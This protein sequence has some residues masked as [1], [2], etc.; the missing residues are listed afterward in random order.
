MAAKLTKL[1]TWAGGNRASRC[2]RLTG[3]AGS[4]QSSSNPRFWKVVDGRLYL[5][6]NGDIQAK[7]L[8]DIPGHIPEAEAN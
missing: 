5:K 7:G 1:R 4:A 8:E 2:T 6:L 3:I